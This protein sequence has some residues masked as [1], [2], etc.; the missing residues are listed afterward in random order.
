MI[1]TKKTRFLIDDENPRIHC[2]V[3]EMVKWLMKR[4]GDSIF[5]KLDRSQKGKNKDT[6]SKK[7][8]RIP[9]C[10][11]N[12]PV[13][14]AESLSRHRNRRFALAR[15][16]VLREFRIFGIPPTRVAHR[17]RHALVCT[18]LCIHITTSRTYARSFISFVPPRSQ[19]C[20]LESAG[21][22]PTAGE[23]RVR[24]RW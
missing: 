14:G 7:G 10:R 22:V 9:I 19:G 12:R 11:K 3:V 4:R 24:S 17:S 13:D 20:L 21:V 8:E 6:G 23:R 1:W 18:H 15:H 2:H 16:V 5:S